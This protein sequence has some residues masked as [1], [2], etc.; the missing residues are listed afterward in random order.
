MQLL[1]GRS[2]AQDQTHKF[3]INIEGAPMFKK[4]VEDMP[5]TLQGRCLRVKEYMVSI[6]TP[7]SGKR[8][9][10]LGACA[11]ACSGESD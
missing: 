6:V 3:S 10:K 7:G 5:S 2:R 11:L 4:H 1:H 8:F 9:L